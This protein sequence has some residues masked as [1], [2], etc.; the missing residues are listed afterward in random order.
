MCSKCDLSNEYKSERIVKENKNE[1]EWI[2]MKDK[3]VNDI[4]TVPHEDNKLH[5]PQVLWDGTSKK[6]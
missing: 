2:A 4:V 3:A 6:N 5:Q 1:E